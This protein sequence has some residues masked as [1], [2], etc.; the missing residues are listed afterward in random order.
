MPDPLKAT[1]LDRLYELR[2][3]DVPLL[4]GG[5]GLYLKFDARRVK[6]HPSV[7]LHA[8]RTDEA[9]A[10]ED[11]AVPLELT[12]DR[13]SGETFTGSVYLPPTYA[14]LCVSQLNPRYLFLY[15]GCYD[16]IPAVAFFEI[17]ALARGRSFSGVV[18]AMRTQWVVPVHQSANEYPPRSPIMRQRPSKTC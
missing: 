9:L 5:Y 14:F 12:G 1:L 8:H 3:A 15:G 16:F 6:P 18:R 17:M 4:L 7:G 10:I 11:R 2:D 13:T